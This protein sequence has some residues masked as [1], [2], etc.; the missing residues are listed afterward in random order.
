M[1][2]LADV[3]RDIEDVIAVADLDMLEELNVVALRLEREVREA[4]GWRGK[5]IR[6]FRASQGVWGDG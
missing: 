4:E 1:T 5:E 2:E 3:E 6:T